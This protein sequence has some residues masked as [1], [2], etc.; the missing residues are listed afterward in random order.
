MPLRYGVGAVSF[1]SGQGVSLVVGGWSMT[2][3]MPY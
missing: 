1:V 3:M 2:K